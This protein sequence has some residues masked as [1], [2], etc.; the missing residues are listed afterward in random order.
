VPN[1]AWVGALGQAV[2]AGV[3]AGVGAVDVV[4]AGRVVVGAGG[5]PATVVLGVA[6]DVGAAAA[7]D[8]VADVGGAPTV[9]PGSVT[10]GLVLGGD[11]AASEGLVDELDP[12]AGATT[13]VGPLDEIAPVDPHAVTHETSHTPTKAPTHPRDI[14]TGTACHAAGPIG[15]PGPV[16]GSGPPV[17]SPG[18]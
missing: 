8:D 18:R 12:A 5:D 16:A 6:A 13:V 4:G 15:S 9:E 7:V 2:P 17:Q 10:A 1:A 14:H 11:V 3:D